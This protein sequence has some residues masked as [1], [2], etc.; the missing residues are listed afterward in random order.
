MVLKNSGVAASVRRSIALVTRIWLTKFSM[1][2][3]IPSVTNCARKFE[4]C[5]IIIVFTPLMSME[6]RAAW[7]GRAVS[8]HDW[9]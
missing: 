4:F 2:N 5:R 6:K 8:T 9:G 7:P 1:A 3:F